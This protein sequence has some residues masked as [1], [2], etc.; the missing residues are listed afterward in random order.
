MVDAIACAISMIVAFFS[1]VG[2]IQLLEVFFLTLFG[3]FLYEV[4]SQ[5]LWNFYITD[6]GFGM[7]IFVFGSFLGLVSSC[8]LGRS[9]TTFEHHQYKSVYSTRSL[10][11]VGLVI[12]FAAFPMLIMAGLYNVS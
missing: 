10:G 3:S 8:F 11:L 6:I 12:A 4:N 1:L 9:D 5:L 2:R 7:R